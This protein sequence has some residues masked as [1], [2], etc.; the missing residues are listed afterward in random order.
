MGGYATRMN[1]NDPWSH[2]VLA[3]QTFM[4]SNFAD[5]IGMH[6]NN[7]Y[8]IIR[9]IVD[10]VMEWEDGKYLILKDPMK[11][12]L[13]IYEVPDSFGEEDEMDDEDLEEDEGPELDEEGNPAPL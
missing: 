11:P 5:Q 1:P 7:I 12:I 10:L 4:T 2:S 3:V 13:R 9:N 8:G 6:R